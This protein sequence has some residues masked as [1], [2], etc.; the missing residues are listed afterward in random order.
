MGAVGNGD[1]G[2]LS[3]NWRSSIC[4]EDVNGKLPSKKALGLVTLSPVQCDS[5][6]KQTNELIQGTMPPESTLE[7]NC[8]S[9]VYYV[10]ILLYSISD[11]IHT[12]F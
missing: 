3:D 12:V 1:E 10:F 8:S 2:V 7:E 5:I 6:S 4:P 11:S 9:I